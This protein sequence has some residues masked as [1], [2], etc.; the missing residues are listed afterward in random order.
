MTA[1][2]CRTEAGTF[3]A[4]RRLVPATRSDTIAES[5]ETEHRLKI[6][7]G[8]RPLQTQTIDRQPLSLLIVEDE[9]IIRMLLL[10]MIEELGHRV[11]GEAARV[12]DALDLIGTGI[13]FD[14]A[15]LDFNLGGENAAPI[16]DVIEEKEIPFVFATGYGAAGV[17]ER[18]RARP[19]L[20]KPYMIESLQKTLDAITVSERK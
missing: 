16:A 17:P 10:D 4:V 19:L 12:K 9:A 13:H 18:F 5:Q 8:K 2:G 6:A 20:Q 14:A 11:A 15:I 7:K 1:C 3:G